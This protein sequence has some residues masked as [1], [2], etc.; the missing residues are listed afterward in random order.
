MSTEIY[1]TSLMFRMATVMLAFFMLVATALPMGYGAA[2]SVYA[3]GHD[4]E[5][6]DEPEPEPEPEAEDRG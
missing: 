6:P 5:P 4:M 3:A 2:G 1:Q